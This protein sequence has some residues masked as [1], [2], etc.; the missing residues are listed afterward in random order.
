MA[1]RNII[2]S[3][4]SELDIIG[5]VLIHFFGLTADVRRGGAQVLVLI[6]SNEAEKI[7]LDD[8]L[9]SSRLKFDKLAQ[10]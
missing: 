8:R 4:G 2:N 10:R 6:K 1:P 7:K 9:I 3:F 5:V